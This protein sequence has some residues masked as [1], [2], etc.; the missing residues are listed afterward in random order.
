MYYYYVA[1]SELT[2][3]DFRA[4]IIPTSY[5]FIFCKLS[6]RRKADSFAYIFLCSQLVCGFVLLWTLMWISR[7]RYQWIVVPPFRSHMT[8]KLAT[9]V[10]VFTWLVALILFFPVYLWFRVVKVKDDQENRS[11]KRFSSASCASA[12]ARQHLATQFICLPL[13]SNIS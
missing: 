9:I 10:T 8:P 7:D 5:Y 13:L 6:R 3:S 1:R 2:L 11:Y 4:F 12:I